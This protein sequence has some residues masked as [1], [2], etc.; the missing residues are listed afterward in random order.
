[1]SDRRGGAEELLDNLESPTFLPPSHQPEPLLELGE[2]VVRA[3]LL[4]NSVRRERLMAITRVG[5][6]P[7]RN[8]ESHV[9]SWGDFALRT[10]T[11]SQIQQSETWSQTHRTARPH[12]CT[13][14]LKPPNIVFS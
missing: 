6:I 10:R 14:N 3:L 12:T 2:V 13:R 8:K 9:V 5:P 4:R 11:T 1:M 7:L